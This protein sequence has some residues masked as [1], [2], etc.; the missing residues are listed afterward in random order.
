LTVGVGT[1]LDA[2]EVVILVSGAHKAHA[3]QQCVENG[4][5]HMWTLSA[6]QMHPCAMIVC[7]DDAT[8]DLKVRTVKYFKG[9]QHTFNMVGDTIPT[10]AEVNSRQPA[11]KKR[12]LAASPATSP[13]KRMK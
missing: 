6:I 13:S 9:L 7:D 10:P 5:N 11:S 1:V 3:L 2:R 12:S 4:V 8:L